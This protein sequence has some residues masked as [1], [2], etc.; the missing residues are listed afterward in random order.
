MPQCASR[1]FA[2]GLCFE[3]SA[4]CN[5]SNHYAQILA[6]HLVTFLPLLQGVD[7]LLYLHENENNVFES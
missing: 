6:K 2:F 1:E 7:Y 3:H 5:T 4:L